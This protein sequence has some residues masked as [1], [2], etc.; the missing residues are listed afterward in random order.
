VLQEVLEDDDFLKV[1]SARRLVNISGTI[2]EIDLKFSQVKDM[3]LPGLNGM[4]YSALTTMVAE[5]ATKYI[6]QEASK[7]II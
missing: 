1:F 2:K 5:I 6:S 3:G 7:R 4:V